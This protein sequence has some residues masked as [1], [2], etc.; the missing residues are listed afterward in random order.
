LNSVKSNLK[1]ATTPSIARFRDVQEEFVTG[2]MAYIW[3]VENILAEKPTIFAD[4]S[5][6]KLEAILG[7]SRKYFAHN[8]ET[9]FQDSPHLIAGKSTYARLTNGWVASVT[10]S[11]AQKFNIL[12]R[13]SALARLSYPQDWEWTVQGATALLADKQAASIVSDRLREE[14]SR[15]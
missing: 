11:N 14:V 9:L 5:R 1:R 8:L 4:P 10:L 2:R 6:K 12:L 15:L 3:L 13:L 7:N